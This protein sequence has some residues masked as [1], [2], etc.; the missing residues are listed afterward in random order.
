MASRHE[1]ES[2]P[3]VLEGFDKFYGFYLGASDYW[4]HY[5]DVDDNGE[6]GLDL[7]Q[8][9]IGLNREIDQLYSSASQ[10]STT[11]CAN[12]AIEWIGD[13][14][15]ERPHVPWYMYLAF[16]GTH[17]SNNKF[18]QAPVTKLK[19]STILAQMRR[20]VNMTYA[21]LHQRAQSELCE[22]RVLQPLQ[23]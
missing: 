11:L 5:S 20:A 14:A 10:Y 15:R 17:S 8:G 19:N 16:Q 4:K 1:N 18:L 3:S 9:S 22:R 2:V 13:H 23:W 6:P 7:H 12:K 21:A